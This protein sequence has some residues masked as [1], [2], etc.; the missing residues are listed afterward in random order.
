M[1]FLFAA[2]LVVLGAFHQIKKHFR[3]SADFFSLQGLRSISRASPF[4]MPVIGEN[5]KLFQPIYDMPTT[6]AT[7]VGPPAPLIEDLTRRYEWLDEITKSNEEITKTPKERAQ[8]AYLELLKQILSGVAYG[9]AEKSV[10]P[11]LGQDQ[12]LHERLAMIRLI[13][14]TPWLD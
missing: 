2:A 12:S 3:V 7:M 6:A 8:L 13:C 14:A 4:D 11:A 10:Q 1:V 9:A 5:Y